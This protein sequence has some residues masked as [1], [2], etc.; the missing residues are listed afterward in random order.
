MEVAVLGE[1]QVAGGLPWAVRG[2]ALDHTKQPWL[3]ISLDY[4]GQSSWRVGFSFC[5]VPGLLCF[6]NEK[7]YRPIVASRLIWWILA[8]LLLQ[9][10]G[11]S[12]SSLEMSTSY[13]RPPGRHEGC[14]TQPLSSDTPPVPHSP[15]PQAKGQPMGCV[16]SE[17]LAKE[18]RKGGSYSLQWPF[19]TP[20]GSR[21]PTTSPSHGNRVL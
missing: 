6:K 12:Y 19:V 7:Q 1:G 5:S 2:W 14:G 16:Y 10:G 8:R 15:L 18:D 13:L 17:F 3:G 21:P 4:R 20:E 11:N 9:R